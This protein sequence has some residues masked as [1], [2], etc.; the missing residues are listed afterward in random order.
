MVIY[1]T[2]FRPIFWTVM[3]LIYAVLMAGARYWA[4]DLGLHMTWWKW[5]LAALWYVL[6]SFAFAGGFTL[7]GERERG[8]GWRHLGFFLTI[9]VV[10]GLALWFLVL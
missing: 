2:F 3:G 1:S 10:F 8:A 5:V 9:T 4:Q 6:L 7:M